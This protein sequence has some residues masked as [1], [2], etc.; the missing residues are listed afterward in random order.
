MRLRWSLILAFALPAAFARAGE[1]EV[2]TFEKAWSLVDRFFYDDAH[3]GVDWKAIR[4]EYR[5]KAEAAED[6]AEGR[7]VIQ[8]MLAEL[9]ASHCSVLDGEVYRGMMA[10]LNDKKVATFGFVLE[11]TEPAHYFVRAMFEGGPAEE[12]GLRTGDRVL[13]IDGVAI[14]DSPRLVDAGF[15]PG[16]PGPKL[17]FVR[18]GEEK[19]LALQIESKRN[20]SARRTLRLEARE[21]NGVDAMRNSA[22]SVEVDGVKVG[23]IHMWYCSRGVVETLRDALKG[24]LA[25][26]DALV[27]DVRG[28]GGYADVVDGV[29]G[30]FKGIPERKRSFMRSARAAQP[31]VWDRPIVVLTDER[32]RSAKEILAYRVRSEDVGLLVGRKTEG[33]VLGAMFYP[34]PDGSYLELAGQAVPVGNV[35]LE[36]V[37]VA[38]DLEVQST[39][40]Y[41]FGKDPIL[42]S[43]IAVAI[44]QCVKEP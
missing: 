18:V 1:L 34:L 35:S 29:I 5:P 36:G 40:P 3:H 19:A 24:E 33:A 26:C 17:F 30:L 44:G 38:P 37:G 14:G 7:A 31:P 39:L 12:T 27:L 32:S 23:I 22:R 16:L 8:K 6:S 11:E 10:E 13:A 28:R 43:G 9:R 20:A 4:D 15:D 41:S 21:M 2:K 25:D 42:T